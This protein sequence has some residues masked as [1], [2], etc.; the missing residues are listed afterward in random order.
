MEITGKISQLM[1]IQS[2]SGAKAWTK[3]DVILE[4][5]GTVPRKVAVS[6]WNDKIQ[7][8]KVGSTLK[9]SV[10]IE[11]REYNGRWYTDIKAWKFDVVGAVAPT[12]DA[13]TFNEPSPFDNEPPF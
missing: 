2:G 5:D 7:Q 4:I 6:F 1:Q 12:P 11:S 3:Q 13:P 8:L 9:V 10:N